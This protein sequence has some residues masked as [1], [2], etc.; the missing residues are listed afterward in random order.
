MKLPR[1]FK[2]LAHFLYLPWIVDLI[3]SLAAAIGVLVVIVAPISNLQFAESASLILGLLVIL[4]G[5]S[6]SV[7]KL[8]NDNIES[9]VFAAEATNLFENCRKIV[10]DYNADFEAS[11][12]DAEEKVLRT[13]FDDW[14]KHKNIRAFEYQMM[15]SFL[16]HVVSENSL[17]EGLKLFLK[18]R[19][20]TSDMTGYFPRL[21]SEID[22]GDYFTSGTPHNKFIKMVYQLANN[23][24]FDNFTDKVLEA[25]EIQDTLNYALKKSNPVI[26]S[27][28]REKKNKER[29]QFLLNK[30][31]E[32]AY[33]NIGSLDQELSDD[34]KQTLILLFKYDERFAI[35]KRQWHT[36]IRR[37]LAKKI[38]DEEQLDAGVE[39]EKTKIQ[40]MLSPQPFS[41]AIQDFSDCI[42]RLAPKEYFMYVIY[43]D[44]FDSDAIGW[45]AEKFMSERVVTRARRYLVEFNRKLTK[46]YPYLRKFQKRSIDANY[47]LFRLN[48]QHFNYYADQK[49]IPNAI[50]RFIVKSVLESESAPDQLA[51]Q[52]VYVKR[53]IDNITISGL[54]FT[55]NL[56]VQNKVQGIESA[57]RKSAKKHSLLIGNIHEIGSIG[58][59]IDSF[60]KIFYEVYFHKSLKRKQ[61]MHYAFALKTVKTIVSNAKELID[62]FDAIKNSASTQ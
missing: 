3:I 48:R 47:Y 39:R 4:Y 43:P 8:N 44:R 55:E 58:N 17:D 22:G 45:S 7:I 29:I 28:L 37:H 1:V 24:S 33:S 56:D 2:V 15:D 16:N 19:I 59:Q 30:C 5:V 53:V 12:N 35:P 62:L 32:N 21:V 25:D 57:V 41:K 26:E 10:L 27:L 34:S 40:E 42:E 31:Y 61:G 60:V 11:T 13:Y 49:S 51:S 18:Y 23:L 36:E 9:D 14:K 6:N 50:K 20:V 46:E 38:H 54:L 52:L